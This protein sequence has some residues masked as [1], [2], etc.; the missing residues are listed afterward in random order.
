MELHRRLLGVTLRSRGRPPNP[1]MGGTGRVAGR[2][3]A[4]AGLGGSGGT[5]RRRWRDG[6]GRRGSWL[7]LEVEQLDTLGEVVLDRWELVEVVQAELL[8]ERRGGAVEDG[9]A[10]PGVGP[11][12]VDQAAGGQGPEHPG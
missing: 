6:M 8:E 10:G 9:L 5:G 2:R 1:G 4:G 11:D 12:L 3:P 7:L